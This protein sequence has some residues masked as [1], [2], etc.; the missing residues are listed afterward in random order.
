MTLVKKA[1]G[2]LEEFDENKI[3]NSLVRTGIPLNTAREV[4][5][6]IIPKTKVIS[7]KE[8]YERVLGELKRV[9]IAYAE[10]YRLREAIMELGPTGFPFEKY[11][12]E[13]LRALN[14]Q[15]TL[16]HVLKGRCVSHEVDILAVKN[17]RKILVECKYRNDWGGRVN[18]KTVLYVYARFL[19]L[20]DRLDEAWIVTN[21]KFTLEAVKYGKCVRLKLVGWNYPPGNGLEELIRRTRKYPLTVLLTIQMVD[22]KILLDYG[23]TTVDKLASLTP[24]SLSELL[25][26]GYE[27][28]F[29]IVSDARNFMKVLT[30]M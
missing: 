1:T 17:G 4:A 28:A 12:G 13:I 25:G 21:A 29:K 26:I 8:I 18:V 19:D 23:I 7:T 9:N 24:E 15:V 5:S 11:I 20:I 16:N 14:F 22:Y 6:K 2:V 27:E 3:V 10:A 30:H